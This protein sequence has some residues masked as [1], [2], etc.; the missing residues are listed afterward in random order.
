MLTFRVVRG[1]DAVV[2]PLPESEQTPRVLLRKPVRP[3]GAKLVGGHKCKNDRPSTII[4][5]TATEQ[6]TH[7]NKTR[8]MVNVGF[9]NFHSL[10]MT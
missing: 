1:D 3:P 4:T 7:M 9:H 6:N 5:T 10:R 2:V 8:T